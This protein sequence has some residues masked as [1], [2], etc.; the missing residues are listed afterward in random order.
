M[1]YA[2]RVEI[3]QRLSQL[4]DYESDMDVFQDAFGDDVVE[5]GLHVLEEQVDV[6]VVVGSDCL[7]QANDI[8]VVQLF[9]DF[10]LSVGAL[11]VSSVLEG[12]EYFFEG[13]DSF[14]GFLLNLPDMP[15]GP[16]PHFFEDCEPLED[17]AFDVGG[18]VL[19][20]K[21]NLTYKSLL[22]S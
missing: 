20:H 21:S 12:V 22:S 6:L 18:V 15:V 2:P 10:D 13:E 1:D 5:V 3:L 16:R 17:V 8:R 7:M 9:Q 4:V 11:G 14:G 19:R